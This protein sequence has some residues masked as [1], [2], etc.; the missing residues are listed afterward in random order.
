MQHTEFSPLFVA[1]RLAAYATPFGK[2]LGFVFTLRTG[3]MLQFLL[4]SFEVIRREKVEAFLLGL[5]LV[6]RWLHC[7]LI[8]WLYKFHMNWMKIHRYM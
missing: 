8:F 6:L 3:G 1:S 4:S 5:I 2:F 7:S